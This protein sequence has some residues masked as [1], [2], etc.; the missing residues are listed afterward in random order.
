MPAGGQPLVSLH[1]AGVRY[2]AVQA[3]QPL[4]LTLHDGERLAL[5]GANGSGKSTLL[6]LLHGLVACSGRRVWHAAPEAVASASSSVAAARCDDG[7]RPPAVMVF[8][9]PFVMSLSV[10]FNVELGLRLNRVPRARRA[11]RV[12]QALQRTGLQPL[13]TRQA[14]ELSGG[15][16]QRLALAR[17]WA[18]RP[19]LLLLDEPTAS[20]DPHAKQE[21]EALIAAIAGDGVTIALAT[22]NL[23]QAKRLATRVVYLEAG[24]LVV[25]L[26]V[27]HFFSPDTR[28]PHEAALFL[29]GELPWT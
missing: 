23:G 21:V 1:A 10:R 27:E 12:E 8:Q 24:R 11:E 28:L 13:A 7:R 18:L 25:D 20:L 2:G 16:Q 17:A 26:P 19:R 14:R 6:K 5:V 22:N 9:R 15:Q 4:A 3:L 29:K